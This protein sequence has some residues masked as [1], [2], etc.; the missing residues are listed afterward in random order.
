MTAFAFRRSIVTSGVVAGLLALAI[1]GGLVHPQVAHAEDAATKASK[2]HYAQGEKLFALGKFEDALAEYQKAFDAKPI[3]DFLFNI[4]Q[5]YRNLGDYDSA[6]FS[7]KKFLKL[8]PDASN[9]DKVQELIDDL[10][11]KKAIGDTKRLG[12]D[13]PKDPPPPV[14]IVQADTPIYKKWW[15]WTGI[16]V[17]GAAGGIGIFE[18]TKGSSPPSTS[19]GVNIVFGK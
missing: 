7:F 11:D 13:K 4:G 9:R 2:K 16:V 15:F 12:L 8:D 6:I 1:P 5:C 18:V 10:E 17:V 19:L 3:P 14:V